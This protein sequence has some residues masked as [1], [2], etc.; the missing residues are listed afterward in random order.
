MKFDA[1]SLHSD[2]Y[3]FEVNSGEDKSAKAFYSVNNQDKP[4]IT[5]IPLQTQKL[6]RF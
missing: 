4:I 5:G 2:G 3:F 1:S 6:V